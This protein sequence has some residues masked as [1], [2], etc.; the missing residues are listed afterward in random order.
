MTRQECIDALA[1]L[2]LTP[3]QAHFVA[4]VARHSGYCLRRQYEASAGLAYGKNVRSFLETLVT[5]GLASR[6]MYVT[7]RGYLYHLHARSVYR[8]LGQEDDRHRRYASPALIARRLMILDTVLGEPE[9]QWCATEAEKV[10]LCTGR[11]HVA[12]ADLPQ[13]A[14]PE[15][16]V[17]GM[18]P[19]RYFGHKLP[20]ALAGTPPRVHLFYLATE[21]GTRPFARFLGDHAGLLRALP[22]WTVVVVQPGHIVS[23]AH[24]ETTFHDVIDATV[25]QAGDAVRALQSHFV[26]R[27]R[28]DGNQVS[29]LTSAERASYEAARL[30]FASAALDAVYRTWISSGA[31]HV[32]P[33][34]VRGLVP[35]LGQLVVRVLPF[36]Y[37]QFG[38]FPGVL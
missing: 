24:W 25:W 20:L 7:N 1:P 35:R 27:A 12:L 29:H 37:Q 22:A 9:A 19:P 30:R 11:F 36:S 5:R 4:T 13:A 2:G 17:P 38:A 18:R 33:A 6:T 16:P 3:R 14:T 21:L 8:A 32:D 10:T 26:T 23:T 15:E 34:L 28:L 31:S